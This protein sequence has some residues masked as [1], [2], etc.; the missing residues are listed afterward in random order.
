MTDTTKTEALRLADQAAGMS[1]KYKTPSYERGVLNG[2]VQE[3]R[4]LS[5]VEAER[6]RFSQESAHHFIRA[7]EWA[8]RAGAMEA[9]RDRLA[10]E[11]EALR[12][13]AQRYR[14]LRAKSGFTP[15]YLE[16]E[17]CIRDDTDLDAAIDAAMGGKE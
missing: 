14:W 7:R 3:L 13:D 12:A 15:V 2:C 4:R 17:G 1:S 10:A 9:D 16:I 11:C 5:P 8:E 6:D